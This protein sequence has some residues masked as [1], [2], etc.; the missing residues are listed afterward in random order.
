MRLKALVIA[1]EL[2]PVRGSECAEGWNIVTRLAK[3]HDV[4]VLYAS[5]GQDEPSPYNSYYR[6]VNTY[7]KE[8]GPI[9]GLTFVNL[10]QPPMTKFIVSINRYFYKITHLGLLILYYWGYNYWQKAALKKARELHK[11]ENFHVVHQLTQIGYREPGYWWKLGIPLFWG[12]TGGTSSLPKKFHKMLSTKFMMAENLRT[13]SNYVQFNFSNRVKKTNKAAS[14]IYVFS[15]E[16]A[17]AFKRR[18]TGQVKIMLDA[19]TINHGEISRPANVNSS[20]IKGIWCGSMI[21]RKALIILLKALSLSEVTKEKVIIQVIGAG[22]LEEKL[23]QQAKDLGLTNIEWM[24]SV[25]RKTV[26][27]LMSEADFFVHT[28]LREATSNVIP[29]AISMGLPVICHDANGMSIAINETCGIKIPLNNPEESINGFHSAIKDLITNKDLLEKLK[30]GATKRAPQISWDS[31]AETI[32]KDY[33][34]V[35][36]TDIKKPSLSFNNV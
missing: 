2:S 14:V 17:A 13:F 3:H 1:H 11:Q 24:K 20:V 7:L 18:A 4:T 15:N 10:D 6:E 28:S 32:A 29:E 22:I 34:S 31:M 35:V 19:G 5:G 26:F 23:H 30:A 25:D 8:N 33:L 16:D 9:D 21:E 36:N 12:P 27:K